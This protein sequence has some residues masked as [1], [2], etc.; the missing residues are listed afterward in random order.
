MMGQKIAT[1]RAATEKK[2]L[3]NHEIPTVGR[4]KWGTRL[5]NNE[6]YIGR[7]FHHLEQSKWHNPYK[8]RDHDNRRDIVL[9]K[10]RN[11]ILQHKELKNALSELKGKHLL[12][13]CYP[14]AC[15]GNVLADLVKKELKNL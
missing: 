12:C 4:I 2:T 8:L 15:H 3:V 7:K 11:Y 13:W 9:E 6:L 5:G 1:Q 10:Y 14:K